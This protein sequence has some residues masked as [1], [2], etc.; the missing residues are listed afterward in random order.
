MR[1]T[2]R[3]SCLSGTGIIAAIVTSLVI[4]GYVYAKGGLLYNPGPLNAQRGEMIRGVHSHAEIGGDCK[5]CHT[6]PW[7]SARMEDRCAV[8]H[9]EI[10][11]QMKHR[12]LHGCLLCCLPHHFTART[13]QPLL[14]TALPP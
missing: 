3:L 11:Q 2:N 13:S 10:A 8:C 9:G 12:N 1:N 14:Q 4:V 5:A 6:A 7:E